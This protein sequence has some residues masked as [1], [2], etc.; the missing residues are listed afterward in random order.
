MVLFL[1]TKMYFLSWT[2]CPFGTHI[3]YLNMQD[4]GPQISTKPVRLLN[5]FLNFYRHHIVEYRIFVF[6]SFFSK[7][8]YL[9]CCII[10]VWLNFVRSIYKC[11]HTCMWSPVDLHLI[12]V[13]ASPICFKLLLQSYWPVVLIGEKPHCNQALTYLFALL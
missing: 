9:S 3:L 11:L 13:Q 4:W 5:I 12:A 8:L 1:Y 10:P 6:L 7:L 2:R